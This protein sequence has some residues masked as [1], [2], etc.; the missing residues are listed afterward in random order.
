[1]TAR[2]AKHDERN[3]NIKYEERG[4]ID[5]DG[6]SLGKSFPASFA[7]SPLLDCDYLHA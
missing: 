5:R 4:L 6:L 1:M 2:L 7:P 3:I